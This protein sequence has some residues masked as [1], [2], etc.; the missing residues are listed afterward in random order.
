MVQ[1]NAETVQVLQSAF[2]FPLSA[3]ALNGSGWKQ[4]MI[5]NFSYFSPT[6]LR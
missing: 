6:G 2:A 4:L 1:M 3:S 5:F